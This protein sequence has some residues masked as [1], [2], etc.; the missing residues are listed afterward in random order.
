VHTMI[1]Y[2]RRSSTTACKRKI[3]WEEQGASLDAF[4][5]PACV[6]GPGDKRIRDFAPNDGVKKDSPG[7][8]TSSRGEGKT[9]KRK[10][11]PGGIGQNIFDADIFRYV[12]IPV[13]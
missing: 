6:G 1:L 10:N 3:S 2:L 13:V 9:T 4:D 5:Q 11:V 7:Q 12:W 8:T